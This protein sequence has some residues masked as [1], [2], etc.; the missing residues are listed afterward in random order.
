MLVGTGVLLVLLGAGLAAR[1]GVLWDVP[2]LLGRPSPRRPLALALAA[3]RIVGVIIAF[4]GLMML[5]L[6]LIG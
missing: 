3:V 1:P 6:G 5:I 2:R 4:V